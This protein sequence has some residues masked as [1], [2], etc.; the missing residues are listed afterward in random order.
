MSL[1]SMFK[2]KG[3]S[4]F[5]YGSNA[6]DVTQGLDLTG[7]TVLLTGCNSG[8]GH[9]TLRV[10]AKRGAHV[11]AAARTVQKAQAACDDVVG[12]TTA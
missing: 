2:G 5:G 7:R 10:L 9:E 6:E 8:I 1:L 11:I 12:E 3:P 4:G